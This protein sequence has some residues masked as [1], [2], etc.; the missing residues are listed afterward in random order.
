LRPLSG[1]QLET[2]E[3][4]VTTYQQAVTP[5][6]R[7]HLEARGIN[8]ATAAT[9]RLGVVA[10]PHPG[11]ARFQNMLA[12]PYLDKADK[13][14]TVRFR[15]LQQHD[16]RSLGHGKYMSMTDDPSRPF[17]IRA[18][19][20]AVAAHSDEIHVDAVILNQLGLFAIAVPGANL[21]QAPYRRM[22]AGFSKVWVW[23]DPDE[24]GAEFVQRLTRAMSRAKGVRIKGGDVTDVYVQGGPTAILS[25]VAPAF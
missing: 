15:C 4:A 3:E 8:A 2:L 13:P 5:E 25:L 16:C 17:N 1:S 24:A 9:F 10:D 18:V 21:W 19:H 20:Q 7:S 14:L 22:L 6:V 12:I 23:G 11:H